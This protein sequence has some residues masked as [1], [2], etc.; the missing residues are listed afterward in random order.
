MRSLEHKR[1]WKQSHMQKFWDTGGEQLNIVELQTPAI[2]CRSSW[3]PL[4]PPSCISCP[5]LEPS[6]QPQ[7]CVPPRVPWPQLRSRGL[8]L[9]VSRSCYPSSEP[10]AND[11]CIDNCISQYWHLQWLCW[12]KNQQLFTGAQ[13]SKIIS[14]PS[15]LYTPTL[16]GCCCP[17]AMGRNSLL[18]SVVLVPW[19]LLL[20]PQLR[21]EDC[22]WILEHYENLSREKNKNTR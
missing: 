14:R 20:L 3:Q 2:L 15:V 19:I 13:K 1:A 8:L 18:S 17:G 6:R 16:T 21:K 12:V 4:H 5:A 9:K 11:S 10:P 22:N 7:C